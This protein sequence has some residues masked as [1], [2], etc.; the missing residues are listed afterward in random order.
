M[1]ARLFAVA[2]LCLSLVGA[3][4]AAGH[5]VV[6]VNKPL[7]IEPAKPVTVEVYNGGGGVW[8]DLAVSIEGL[9]RAEYYRGVLEPL[10]F[11]QVELHAPL[12]LFL[13]G[14]VAATLSYDGQTLDAREFPVELLVP[15]RGVVVDPYPEVPEVYIF[16][17][18][19]AAEPL[20]G[21]FVEVSII[22]GGRVLY[23]D[24]FG[25]FVVIADG[26]FIW[27]TQVPTR[28]LYGGDFEVNA[29]F[30]QGVR[31][32]STSEA[33]FSY[34]GSP[35]PRWSVAPLFIVVLTFLLVFLCYLVIGLAYHGD[36]RTGVRG[37][38]RR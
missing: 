18:N 15:V 6:L 23:A 3:V 21:L 22:D 38:P 12:R 33:W 11:G 37:F 17:R 36:V 25:P 31:E 10:S 29:R 20:E 5:G 8:S 24:L 13:D 34:E 7:V 1:P 14:R 19:E 28:Y 35:P 4:A 16:Y 26:Q 30:S 27:S 9:P 2:L 32:L